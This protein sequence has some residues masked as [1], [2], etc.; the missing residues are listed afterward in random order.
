MDHLFEARNAHLAALVVRLQR[1]DIEV[2]RSSDKDKSKEDDDTDV[3][4]RLQLDEL[5][6]VERFI[7]DYRLAVDCQL[8]PD[9]DRE[10]ALALGN[11]FQEADAALV[12]CT[13]CEF[14]FTRHQIFKASCGHSYCFDCLATHFEYTLNDESMYP[15]KCCQREIVFD[16]VHTLLDAKLVERYREK[17]VEYQTEPKKRTYCCGASCGRFVPE[18]HIKNDVATCPGCAKRTCTTCKEAAH[19][20]D[21]P[22]DD[23]LQSLLQ[24][25]DDEGWQRCLRCLRVVDLRHGC[26]HIT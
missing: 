15:P 13:V 26:N 18:N 14:K 22:K 25:A 4:L 2:L 6:L 3:A 12:T 16:N 10:F 11:R 17:I 19:R 24:L 5:S 23:D 1:E 20:G 7:A 9:R 21:C 8:A